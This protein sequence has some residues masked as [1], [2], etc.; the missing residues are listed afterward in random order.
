MEVIMKKIV[1]K[2]WK[3]GEILTDVGHM[4][5]QYNNS[6]SDRYLLQTED[7]KYV[8][9][10]KSTVVKIEDITNDGR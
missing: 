9:I 3:T 7:G 5:K 4:P 10:I 2:H 1:Y 8:D 6:Q